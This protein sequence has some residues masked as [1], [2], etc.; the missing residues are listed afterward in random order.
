MRKQFYYIWVSNEATLKQGNQV[1]ECC[2]GVIFVV[3]EVRRTG[4]VIGLVLTLQGIEPGSYPYRDFLPR[5][6]HNFPGRGQDTPA[7]VYPNTSHFVT[8]C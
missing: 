5:W 8:S 3:G 6:G 4:I 1:L 7:I 2:I